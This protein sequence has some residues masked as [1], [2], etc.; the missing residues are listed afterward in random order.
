[1]MAGISSRACA[2]G[3][4]LRPR[5]EG[6]RCRRHGLRRP[7][8]RPLGRRHFSRPACC[9]ARAAGAYG[10]DCSASRAIA[11]DAG[12]DVELLRAIGTSACDVVMV[13][14]DG[15]VRP[16]NGD[17]EPVATAGRA[18]APPRC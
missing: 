5:R 14:G 1:M 2:V 15:T 7:G 10:A 8:H 9:R 16:Y 12:V 11:R 13:A 17:R 4:N 3:G 18:A 6:R